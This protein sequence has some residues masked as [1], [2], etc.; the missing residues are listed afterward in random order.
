MEPCEQGPLCLKSQNADM[1][2]AAEVLVIMHSL[3]HLYLLPSYWILSYGYC[4]VV[5]LILLLR[6]RARSPTGQPTQ[7]ICV[8][9]T[10]RDISRGRHKSQKTN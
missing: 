1:V 4:C 9:G 10:E 6:G 5:L 7:I 3:R 8:S 2:G